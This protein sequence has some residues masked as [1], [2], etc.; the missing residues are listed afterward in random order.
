MAFGGTTSMFHPT[1]KISYNAI[2]LLG[3]VQVG[4]NKNQRG[5]VRLAG[6]CPGS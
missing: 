5:V 1:I 6:S 3:M 4:R 2:N